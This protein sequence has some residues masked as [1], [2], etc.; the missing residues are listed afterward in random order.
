VEFWRSYE[1][2]YIDFSSD[3]FAFSQVTCDIAKGIMAERLGS[4]EVALGRRR[5]FHWRKCLGATLRELRGG[6]LIDENG[7]KLR[8][9]IAQYVLA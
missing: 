5:G 7:G 4:E 1:Y 3:I 2:G 6:A 9:A 8:A